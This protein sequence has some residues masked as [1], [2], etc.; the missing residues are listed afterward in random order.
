MSTLTPEFS[1]ITFEPNP[2]TGQIE[3]VGLP[4]IGTTIYKTALMIDESE[5]ALRKQNPNI[6]E[7][8]ENTEERLKYMNVVKERIRICA[9]QCDDICKELDIIIECCDEMK[10]ECEMN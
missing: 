3:F 10:R 1:K 7:I 2:I 6:K 9:K 4:E 5:D 8:R